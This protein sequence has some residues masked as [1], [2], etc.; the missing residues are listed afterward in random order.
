MFSI[1]QSN[2]HNTDLICITEK[3]SISETKKDISKRKM[4]LFC[5]LKGLSNK[6]KLFFTS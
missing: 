4:P 5:I 1:M 2:L 6:Q 3:R